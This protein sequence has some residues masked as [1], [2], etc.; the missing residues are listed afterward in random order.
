MVSQ[1]LPI[2]S[3]VVQI[4]SNAKIKVLAPYVTWASQLT[5]LGLGFFIHKCA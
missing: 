3:A 4:I 2:K 1:S 5:C